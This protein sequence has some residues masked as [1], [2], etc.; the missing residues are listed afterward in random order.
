MPA[1]PPLLALD[2]M[3]RT[4]TAIKRV[5]RQGEETPSAEAALERYPELAEVK[6]IVLDLAFEEY[7]LRRERGETIDL[8]EFGR[9]FPRFQNDIPKWIA[10]QGF[11]ADHAEDLEDDPILTWPEPGHIVEGK[12]RILRELGR[13]AFSRAYLALEPA[14]DDRPVVLKL[15]LEGADEARVLGRRTHRNVARAFAITDSPTYGLTVLCMPFVGGATLLHVLSKLYPGSGPGQRTGAAPTIVAEASKPISPAVT[16][17]GSGRPVGAAPTAAR[18]IFAAAASVALAGDPAPDLEPE[19]RQPPRALQRASFSDGVAELGRQI[20]QALAFLHANGVVHRDLKPSNIL[21]AGNWRPVLLDFGLALDGR[22]LL[23]RLG[24]TLPYMAPEA[25]D[26]FLA[27]T[28]PTDEEG[29][30]GDVFAVGVILYELLTGRVPFGGAPSHLGKETG[31]RL[32]RDLQRQGL[33]P[34]RVLNPAV[35]PALAR[36]VERC[37]SL[38]AVGRPTAHE[39]ATMLGRY[40]GAI[41]RFTRALRRHWAITAVAVAGLVVGS[42]LAAAWYAKQPPPAERDFQ[43][44]LSALK[45]GDPIEAEHW[46]KE[47]DAR[48]PKSPTIQYARGHARIAKEDFAGALDFLQQVED[49]WGNGRALAAKAYCLVRVTKTQDALPAFDAAIRAGYKNAIVYNNRGVVREM[50]GDREGARAD[51]SEA[52]HRDSG[53]F[54]AYL[55]RARVTLNGIPTPEKIAAAKGDLDT[56]MSLREPTAGLLYEVARVAIRA[57]NADEALEHLALAAAKGL[58]SKIITGDPLLQSGL[59]KYP[60]RLAEITRIAPEQGAVPSLNKLVAPPF[61]LP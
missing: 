48:V 15:T 41:R 33:R 23:P 60:Q 44:G 21:L 50:C 47:A 53:L 4:A 35:D 43:R 55:N 54:E 14:F 8:K 59:K 45:A 18:A 42:V 16:V 40:H 27:K 11:F 3:R 1:A 46:F 30:R 20:A 39:L 5:W 57:G 17:T 58:P 61:E 13:G 36:I 25:I 22:C 38:D 32:Q 52:I 12:Y 34:I 2:P 56:A 29:R 7:Q 51:Y 31:A 19:E 9:G 24:G 28:L 37:L 49:A 6:S 10:V 26:A